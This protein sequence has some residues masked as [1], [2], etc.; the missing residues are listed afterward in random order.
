MTGQDSMS[1]GRILY[2]VHQGALVLR[3]DGDVR[4]D[5]CASLDGVIERVLAVPGVKSLI[6]DLHAATNID[7]T[8][9]GVLA[10]VAVRMRERSGGKPLAVAPGADIRRLLDSMC[11][12]KVFNIVDQ[13][14]DAG[15]ECRDV[16]R[17]ERDDDE[18]C[19]QVADAHRVL[20]SID[21][22]NFIAFRDVVAA[23]EA[24][25]PRSVAGG[26]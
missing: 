16:P 2:T 7:S 13:S 17:V 11:L 19:R 9:L 18:L 10:R 26:G 14:R 25:Q 24:Q 22:R 3:L 1:C 23:L 21:D 6:V 20:M 4:A 5:W 8:M 15:C 12:D